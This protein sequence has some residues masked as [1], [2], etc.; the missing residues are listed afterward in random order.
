M[1]ILIQYMGRAGHE[2]NLSLG[3]PSRSDTNQT[4]QPQ[5]MAILI[6]IKRLEI[7][8]VGSQGIVLLM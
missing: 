2:K 1:L 5:K 3:F 7:S 4:V 6:C 8:D